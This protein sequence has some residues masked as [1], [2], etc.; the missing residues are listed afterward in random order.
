MIED[1]SP[2]IHG[3][4]RTEVAP[5]NQYHD[6]STAPFKVSGADSIHV[7]ELDSLH[8]SPEGGCGCQ[9]KQDRQTGQNVFEEKPRQN[10]QLV[11]P[12]FFLIL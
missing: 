8:R 7:H 4:R 3:N 2:P 11:T 5:M 12:S 1:G 9:R 6:F 10:I